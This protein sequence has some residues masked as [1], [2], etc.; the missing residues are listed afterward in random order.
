MEAHKNNRPGIP[1]FPDGQSTCHI[2]AMTQIDAIYFV[3]II[4]ISLLLATNLVIASGSR[5]A[6]CSSA[7]S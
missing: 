4:I 5:G 7:R 2:L 6:C 1:A 3:S